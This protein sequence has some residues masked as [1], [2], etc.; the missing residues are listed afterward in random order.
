[1]HAF[2]GTTLWQAVSLR[3]PMKEYI[4]NDFRRAIIAVGQ[5]RKGFEATLEI[6]GIDCSTAG[7][8]NTHEWKTLKTDSNL[9]KSGRVRQPPSP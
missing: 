7:G 8:K 4:C 1:M 9:S 2:I 3:Q 5:S 6:L